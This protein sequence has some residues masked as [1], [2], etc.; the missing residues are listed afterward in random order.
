MGFGIPRSSGNKFSSLS[1]Q[2]VFFC[3]ISGR[4]LCPFRFHL[5]GTTEFDALRP[6]RC[7]LPSIATPKR[8]SFPSV[9]VSSPDFRPSRHVPDLVALPEKAGGCQGE[10]GGVSLSV[11]LKHPLRKIF[12]APSGRFLLAVTFHISL[13]TFIIS[14]G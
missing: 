7:A 4:F 11:I 13:G 6:S 14:P 3:L 5:P 2:H 12:A 1:G 9:L 10:G 8:F